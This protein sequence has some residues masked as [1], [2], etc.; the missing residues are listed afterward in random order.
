MT[1][2]GDRVVPIAPS[3]DRLRLAFLGWQCRLRQLS[4]RE[5][6]AKPS[7]GMQPRLTV[8]GQD[9]GRLTVLIT[10]V[11]PAPST[12]EF[13]HI[14]RRTHDPQERYKTALRYLQ[15]AYFQDPKIFDDGLTVVF[16]VDAEL[17]QTLDGRDDCVLTFE[18][19][20]Q[21]YVLTC[22]ATCLAQDDPA[23]QATYWHNALFNASLPALVTILHFRPDW[24]RAKAEPQV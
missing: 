6:G 20:N 2:S 21:R 18:Q 17:P 13:R 7:S 14:V 12:H 16:G 22:E 8:A 4:V 23:F 11:D 19:F 10:P 9:L 3:D 1:G 24:T 5:F 15:A